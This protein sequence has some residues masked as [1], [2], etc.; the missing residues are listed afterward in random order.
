MT[1]LLI[2]GA[3]A[4]TF[5]Q[6]N[7]T[8]RVERYTVPGPLTKPPGVDFAVRPLFVELEGNENPR[9][10]LG[11]LHI[12][13][14]GKLEC[15]HDVKWL[16]EVRWLIAQHLP[17]MTSLFS[18]LTK[19]LAALTDARDLQLESLKALHEALRGAEGSYAHAIRVVTEMGSR[20]ISAP[21][22]HDDVCTLERRTYGP[23]GLIE[24]PMV[25]VFFIVQ[26]EPIT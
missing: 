21:V 6:A 22:S 19:D 4:R 20:Q 11:R 16:A 13:V 15:S 10:D 17:D 7:L 9:G 14:N 25:G 8:T 3:V 2:P 23:G 26:K 18:K 1:D 24:R 5:N 12:L